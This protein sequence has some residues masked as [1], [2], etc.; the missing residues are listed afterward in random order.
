M[1]PHAFPSLFR[2]W[3]VFGTRKAGQ[4]V[5]LCAAAIFLTGYLQGATVTFSTNA[6]VLGSIIISNLT[7]GPPSPPHGTDYGPDSNIDGNYTYVADD[8]SVPGQTFTT[9]SDPNGYR[10]VAVTLRQVVYNTFALVP[11]INYTVRITRPLSTNTL[12]VIATETAAVAQ[13]WTDCDTCNFVTIGSGNSSGPGTGRYITFLLDTPVL[14]AR[15]T[16]YG[17]DVGGGDVRHYW[18]T[19]GRDSTPDRN[20]TP[21]DPYLGGNAY[22]SGLWNGHGD[23][24]MTNHAGDRVFVVAMTSGN[25]VDPPR[26]T[27]DPQSAAYYAGLTAQFSAQAAGGTNLAYQ[28]RKD[29]ANLSNGTKYSGALTD[30]L[31]ISNV[32]AT[33]LGA[34][35][36]FVTN[37]A[38]STSSAPARLTA[39]VAPPVAGTSYGYAIFTNRALAHWRLNETVD[40]STNPPA[41]DYIGGRIGSYGVNALKAAGPRPSAFPGFE[42]DNS[43]VQ[44]TYYLDQS[45][46][47][48]PALNLDTNTVSFTAW[49]YPI[50]AQAEFA[51]LFW[52][53]AGGTRAGMA[54]GDHWTTPSSVGQL[55]YTW[56]QGEIRAFP[57]GLEIPSDQ[58]SFV[59]LV[60][61][62]SGG[63]LYL[64]TGG[65]LASA[66]NPIPHRSELWEGAA[67]IGY[68]PL[69]APERIFNGIVD[70]VAVFKRSLSLDEISTLY[71]VGRGIVQ[72]V[73]PTFTGDP[74]GS[75]AFYV[76]RTARFHAAVTGTSPLVYRWRK[77]GANINDDGRI[78]G[79]QTDTLTISNVA[80]GDAGAYTLVVTNSAGAITSAPPATLTIINP[81]G[82]AY[83]A[84]VCAA[85]PVAYWRLNDTGD[86]ST[87]AP[88]FEYWGGFV[89]V[90]EMAAL[91]G[92]NS[93]K[94]PR[95]AEFAE[96][97]NGNSAWGG[98][99]YTPSSWV[100]VPALNLNTN[101]VT[102]TLWLQP[103]QDPVNDLA[104]LIFTRQGSASVNG[105][106]LRYTTNSQLS[107]VWNL[108]AIRFDSGLS[109][110]AGQWSFAALVVEPTQATVY[111]YN[112]NGLASATNLIAHI[113]E[114]WDGTARIGHDGGY[115]NYN[116]PGRIDEVA[117]FN[118]AFTPAQVFNLYNAAF[119]NQ[120]PAVT[121][122]IQRVGADVVLSWA[123]G[124][125]LEANALT[126]PWTTNNASSPYTNAPTSPSKFY[127][128]IVR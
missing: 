70:E 3:S 19:D 35:T 111:V 92:F 48:V 20:H 99:P 115:W 81:S 46:A 98:A 61:S 7:G 89:G 118:Y 31:S 71:N 117:V 104:G 77:E 113:P 49:I 9:G 86:P 119:T 72:A 8:K 76:G 17:F 75:Q 126:G 103:D 43:G 51:G 2:L 63:T 21:Q 47:T 102:F 101:A 125:L 34:Y 84:A 6:P 28:W 87:N 62:P 123:Q 39:V 50:G 38:G 94:G 44:S 45:W 12:S 110:P 41:Y 5:A 121:L 128:V 73:P 66:V 58:W 109:T 79:A 93:V 18:E 53:D 124:T 82:K 65:T 52:S 59:A 127:R 30:T 96:F 25:V 108:G 42:S 26:I 68:D 32:A 106:G 27:R 29:G 88:A 107:Y 57:S 15:N 91:N 40:P 74:P 83:E 85:G 90:Y 112:T 56:N 116:F 4:A 54:Y 23:T 55:T 105:C 1:K 95:P 100:T 10:L 60:I 67:Q 78:S 36:L 122:G 33:D 11:G 80:A 22:N 114:A 69:Y 97:E 37:S 120:P 24:T 13:D 14:L 16:T 64:G